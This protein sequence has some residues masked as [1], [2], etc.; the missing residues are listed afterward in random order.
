MSKLIY[1]S[2]FTYHVLLLSIVL[3]VFSAYN[4]QESFVP[5]IVKENYRPLERNIRRNV[6][7]FYGRSSTNISNIFRKFGII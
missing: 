3:I 6:E 4:I 2:S 1:K 7:E 5:K